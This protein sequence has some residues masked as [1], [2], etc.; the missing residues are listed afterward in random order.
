MYTLYTSL[1]LGHH[2]TLV[3][4]V[5][6]INV[7]PLACILRRLHICMARSHF[8]LLIYSSHCKVH[9]DPSKNLDFQKQSG[10]ERI[11]SNDVFWLIKALGLWGSITSMERLTTRQNSQCKEEYKRIK[12]LRIIL[13]FATLQFELSSAQRHLNSLGQAK[14]RNTIHYCITDIQ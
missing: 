7:W 1:S 9:P 6:L 10:H 2:N 14:I 3:H 4:T 8:L 5:N 11:K 12:T 13:L